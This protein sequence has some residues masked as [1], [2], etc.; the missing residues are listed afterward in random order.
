MSNKSNLTVAAHFS[1]PDLKEPRAL[2]ETL[3]VAFEM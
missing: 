2:I 1:T 3:N